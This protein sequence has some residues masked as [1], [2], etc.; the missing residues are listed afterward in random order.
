MSIRWP[1]QCCDGKT[2]GMKNLHHC[3]FVHLKTFN[4][5]HRVNCALPCTCLKRTF[6][7]SKKSTS[8]EVE[9]K[10][11]VTLK[12]AEIQVTSPNLVAAKDKSKCFV[13]KLIFM[14]MGMIIFVVILK[15]YF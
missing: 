12:E 6:N 10:E 14:G 13:K 4:C 8:S 3:K 9:R 15:G 7:P 5:V 1:P 2:N 11:V